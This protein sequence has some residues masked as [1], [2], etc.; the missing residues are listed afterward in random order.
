MFVSL[1]KTLH[2]SISHLGSVS[3]LAS[4]F[5]YIYIYKSC[6]QLMNCTALRNAISNAIFSC[7]YCPK[8]RPKPFS[9]ID[10][11]VPVNEAVLPSN[12]ILSGH[13][14]DSGSLGHARSAANY[15]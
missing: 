12:C 5:I 13:T 9:H 14:H 7:R 10:G 2:K 8:L 11:F 3:A 15:R 4:Q 6:Y 1:N